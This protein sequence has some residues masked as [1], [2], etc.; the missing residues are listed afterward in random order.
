MIY[1][2]SY[3]REEF[4]LRMIPAIAISRY[5]FLLFYPKYSCFSWKCVVDSSVYLQLHRGSKES[6]TL[7]VNDEEMKREDKE[8]KLT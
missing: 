8:K 5:L 3:Q 4:E 7:P 1:T 6:F 2:S